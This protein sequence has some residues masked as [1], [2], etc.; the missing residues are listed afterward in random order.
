LKLI[1]RTPLRN[2]VLFHP[3][4]PP[5]SLAEWIGKQ[6]ALMEATH[7]GDA[8]VRAE[9]FRGLIELDQFADDRQG[10]AEWAGELAALPAETPFLRGGTVGD[11]LDESA[12]RPGN[13]F[14]SARWPDSAPQ[15]TARSR[16]S[17]RVFFSQF[18]VEVLAGGL[19]SRINLELDWPGCQG[20]RYSGSSWTQEWMGY[21]P[22]SRRVLR[23]NHDLTLAWG[24][25]RLCVLQCGSE[26]FGLSPFE[27]N[28]D[29]GSQRLWPSDK[30]S[31]DTLGDASNVRLAF[32]KERLPERPG[33]HSSRVQLL[34]EFGHPAA[35]VGPVDVG[36]LC[37]QEQGM[38]V[39]LDP[40]TGTELW[41]RYDLPPRTRHFGDH[42][43]I[44][45]L[46]VASAEYSVVDPVDGGTV[47]RGRFPASPDAIVATTGCRCLLGNGER[48]R[49]AAA[50]DAEPTG[51]DTLTTSSPG[52][53]ELRL[54]DVPRGLIIWSRGWPEGSFPVELDHRR[55]G[56]LEP[57]GRF[58]ILE[59]ATGNTVAEHRIDNSRPIERVG[60]A[61]GRDDLLIAFSGPVDDRSLTNAPQRQQGYRRIYLDGEMLAVDR[62]SGD[63]RWRQRLRNT[64]FPLDQPCD[65]PV[66]VT[67]EARYP[68]HPMDQAGPFSGGA[69]HGSVLR[70]YDRRSGA[71]LY[72]NESTNPINVNYVFHNRID[73]SQL[74]LRTRNT[75][76]EFDFSETVGDP[77]ELPGNRHTD[78]PNDLDR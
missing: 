26:L 19:Y 35:A 61:V 39:A 30:G 2:T 37:Y 11:W 33:Y 70:V 36:V 77:A 50:G 66:F 18:P 62:K 74:V 67:A 15:V 44:V 60:C 12:R 6:L 75:T 23:T 21:L 24:L 59:S 22:A 63:L 41:R 34:N 9:A 69:S 16:N 13:E 47:R 5:Q 29:R 38:F 17:T 65:F 53:L 52:K 57:S 51:D 27:F 31:I 32:L 56:V 73:L 7:D 10:I 43:G 3:V 45:E 54:F 68:E 64:V 42:T 8:S 71:E 78:S 76:V 58:E 1:G 4:T 14:V 25:G 46:N 28:G 40:A 49:L 55:V 48:F 72:V 20:V